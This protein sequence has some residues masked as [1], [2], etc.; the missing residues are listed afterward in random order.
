MGHFESS[1]EQGRSVT[2]NSYF[3][4]F[5]SVHAEERNVYIASYSSFYFFRPFFYSA[6]IFSCR[7]PSP[8]W[9]TQKVC[10][11]DGTAAK[12]LV[13]T[14]PIYVFPCAQSSHHWSCAEEKENPAEISMTILRARRCHERRY[15][16]H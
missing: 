14:R 12:Y 7:P 5:R 4:F 3:S 16:Y 6:L 9:D 1:S 8:L 11:R 2:M 13:T 10:R 15:Y